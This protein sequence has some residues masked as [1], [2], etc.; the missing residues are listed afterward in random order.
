MR[1]CDGTREHGQMLM[2]I[3]LLLPMLL[4]MTAMAVDL[5]AYASERRNLQ[6]DA[7][8]IALAAA[9]DLPDAAAVQSSAASWEAKNG[10]D[11]GT[12][13]VSVTVSG[14]T[15]TPQVK[16]QITRTHKFAFIRIVGV[17]DQDVS[18]TAV[19]GK[20]SPGGLSGVMPWA[21]TQATLD[22]AAQGQI[23]TIKQGAGGGYTGNYGAMDLDGNGAATYRDSVKYG[24]SSVACANTQT[25][26]TAAACPGAYPTGCAEDSTSCDGPDCDSEPGNM[27]GPTDAA[28]SYRLG[29]TMPQCSTFAGAFTQ[30]S[31]YDDAG[32]AGDRFAVAATGGSS[33]GHLMS[34]LVAPPAKQPTST[35]TNTPA[36]PT[37]TNTP[38]ATSTAAPTQ[39][40]TPGPSPTPMATTP[41]TSTPAPTSTSG[42]PT[43]K[44]NSACNPWGA[45][46]CPVPDDGA[47]LCS[48][49]VIVIPVIAGLCNGKC[50][51]TILSFALFF[52]EGSSGGVVTGRFVSTDVNMGAWA[53]AYDPASPTHFVKLIQ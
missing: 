8:A 6:N 12:A 52:L 15:T 44:L 27:V 45:G 34:P 16:V 33:G 29:L 22:A 9:Q 46:K 37:A 23:V 38:M 28:V 20:F 10:V 26:C 32:Q 25:N 50:T 1:S 51:F 21:V 11:P 43:Y 5:G 4:G 24:S 48:R 35:P 47:T 36:P 30:A 40:N 3:A 49:Q 39:T 17:P 53:S 41:A 18:A 2:V 14:G 13:I 42:G 19:A 31:S 7:D